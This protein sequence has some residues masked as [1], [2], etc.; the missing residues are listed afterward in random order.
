MY[1]FRKVLEAA[2]PGLGR[3]ASTA[4]GT[5][6]KSGRYRTQTCDLLGVNQTL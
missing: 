2:L 5:T 1:Y 3:Y 4:F 6:Y